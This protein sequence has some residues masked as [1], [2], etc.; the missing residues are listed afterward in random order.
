MALSDP[1]GYLPEEVPACDLLRERIK[2]I[3]PR[4]AVYGHIHEGGVPWGKRWRLAPRAA[5]CG[6]WKARGPRASW[7]GECR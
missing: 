2:E 1:H 6:L 3:R 7:T 4:L 5:T